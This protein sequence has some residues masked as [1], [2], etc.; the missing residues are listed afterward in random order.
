[1]KEHK[2]P[3]A[4]CDPEQLA[5]LGQLLG[6]ATPAD[7][8]RSAVEFALQFA[9]VARS[10]RLFPIPGGDPAQLDLLGVPGAAR[11]GGDDG[12]ARA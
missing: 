1:M 3:A 4:G 10:T 2:E 6:T 12:I 5:R 11:R 8:L 9:E 7:T